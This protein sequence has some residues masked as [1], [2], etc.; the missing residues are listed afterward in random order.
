[1]PRKKSSGRRKRRSSKRKSTKRIALILAAFIVILFG[2]IYYLSYLKQEIEQDK[3]S[4]TA[5]A[6]DVNSEI[7][8][9]DKSLYRV[10]FDLG[11]TKKDILKRS[12]TVKLSGTSS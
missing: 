1:M 8:S 4:E 3:I 11:I 12:S 5:P 7:S 6:V 9:I 10:L 2:T